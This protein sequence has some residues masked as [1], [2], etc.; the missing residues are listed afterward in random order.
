MRKSAIILISL[1]L[2][3]GLLS[4][5]NEVDALRYS[6]HLYGGTAR[7][8]A[9]GGAFGALGGDFGGLAINPAGAGVFRSTELTIT[10]TLYHRNT[11]S[12]FLGRDLKDSRY[13]FNLNNLGMVFSFNTGVDEGWV[14]TS[15]ALGYNRINN[16]YGNSVMEGVMSSGNSS[17]SSY[18]DNFTYFANSTGTFDPEN[19]DEFYE[20]VAWNT[21]LLWYDTI[22]HEYWND[23]QDA[24]YGQTMRRNLDTQGRIG[25]YTFAF[26]ANYSHKL[27]LG[28]SLGIHNVKYEERARHTES[29]PSDVIPYLNSFT[30]R[31]VLETNGTGY[32]FKM[33]GIFRPVPMLRIGAAFHLPTF[34]KLTDRFYTSAH[35][36][37]DEVSDLNDRSRVYDDEYR[38]RTPFKAIGSIGLQFKKIGLMSLDYEYIDYSSAD[39]D[40]G[41][42]D[43]FEENQT[44][45][46]IYKPASN[47]RAGGEVRLGKGYIRGG[48]ALYG[49]AFKESE[50]NRDASYSVYSLGA[51]LRESSFFIDFAWSLTTHEEMYYLYLLPESLGALQNSKSTRFLATVGFRF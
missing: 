17:S 18:L 42:Y 39:M 20:K 35:S 24:G 40:G 12:D 50:V 27:Y 7:S 25:E 28:A 10:P 19:L 37:F 36:T 16:F 23:I 34:Y 22:A 5:Q 46:R 4:A 26:G 32:T 45:Q 43:F 21:E 9:M 6:Q 11:E 13:N 41:D 29:D 15:F 33:G 47:I 14:S 8:V 2:V 31:E 3:P 48:Y 38:I 1:L 30:F 44:I 49:S 51:G